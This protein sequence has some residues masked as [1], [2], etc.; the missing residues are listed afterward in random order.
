M[1]IGLYRAFTRSFSWLPL[2]LVLLLSRISM[3]ATFWR[4]GQTKVQNFAIDLVDGRFEIGWP[5]L[6]DSAIDLFRDE[7][8]LPLISPDVAAPLAALA[9][10]LLALLLLIGLCS[11]ASALGLFI[12]T[13]V[14]QVFV[15]P[16][17]WP[18]HA[19]WAVCLLVVMMFGPGR[20]SLDRAFTLEKPA[21]FLSDAFQ[22]AGRRG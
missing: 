15:Y 12:M 5:R 6:S 19:S 22:Y 8:R 3:A 9:E 1:M 20:L 14:I 18:L 13:A 2:D 17:A 11:R 10:H 21:P 4:S 7:Y 16:G